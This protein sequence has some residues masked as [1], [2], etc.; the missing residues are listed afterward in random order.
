MMP[1]AFIFAYKDKAWTIWHD[2]TVSEIDEYFAIGSGSEVARGVLYATT[3][4]NPF[5]RIV[6]SIEA[7]AEST[8]YVDTGIDL[9]ATNKYEEDLA[10]MAIALG[11]PLSK[12][13]TKGSVKEETK[14]KKVSKK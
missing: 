4:R 5:D 2:L 6:T 10:D 13:K 7:A 8:L 1:N 14:N 12:P 3:E 11:I 9:L